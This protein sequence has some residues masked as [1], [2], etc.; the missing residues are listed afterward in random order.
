[1]PTSSIRSALFVTLA[2]TM[3]CSSEPPEVSGQ[4][5]R[6]QATSNRDMPAFAGSEPWTTDFSKMTVP[7]KEI[8]S[9]GPPR[10]GIPAIDNPKFITI[11]QAE[12][13]LDDRDPLAVVR[14]GD[15]VRAYP[16]NILIWHEIVNDEFGGV[17][18]SVTFCPLCNTTLAFDRRFDGKV[19]DFGTT[20]RLRH[21]DLVMYDRQTE[22]WWQQATGEGI[23]GEYAGERLTFISAPVMSWK[24]VKELE[25]NAAVLSRDTGH[26][27]DYGRNPYAGYDTGRGPIGRF[28]EFGR[29]DDRLNAMER[30]VALE[31]GDE[32]LA[33]PFG[34]L[35][36]KKIADVDVGG[37][38]MVV[39]WAPGTASALDESQISDGRDVGSSAVF[40]PELNGRRLTFEEAGEGLFLDDQ[41]GSLWNM[42]GVATEGELAGQRLEPVPHGNHFWFAWGTFRPETEIWNGR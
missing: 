36:D 10:D 4:Q 23:I 3:A 21:S 15:E 42:S 24:D 38:E 2:L 13:D 32:F 33:V 1:M 31:S 28:F 5:A 8:A 9:G 19:L 25:P 16:L 6:P 37:V 11:R 22:T 7:A 18:V 39:F 26:N 34:R 40:N 14:I 41:T 12:R 35:A 17:P 30:V 29:K 20:G 27:R